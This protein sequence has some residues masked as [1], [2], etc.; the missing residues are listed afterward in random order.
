M[1][2]VYQRYQRPLLI[3]ETSHVGSG[4]GAWIKEIAQQ[5]VLARQFDI[6]LQGICLYPVLDRPDW[7]DI[8]RWH[9]SGL[10]EVNT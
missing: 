1:T 10:W 6:D 4:R 9:K 2:E 3:S 7:E 8:H 5:V